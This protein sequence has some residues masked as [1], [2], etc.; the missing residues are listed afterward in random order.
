MR[1]NTLS[2][3][4][5]LIWVALFISCSSDG[6]LNKDA[7]TDSFIKGIEDSFPEIDVEVNNFPETDSI[8]EPVWLLL[9]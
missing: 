3:I 5:T 9:P 2:I 6:S 4:I 8:F 7:Y 1:L